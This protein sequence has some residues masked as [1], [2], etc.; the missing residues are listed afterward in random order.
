VTSNPPVPVVIF[1][2][3]G[4]AADLLAFAHRIVNDDGHPSE[5]FHEVQ[6]ELLDMI[7]K[8]FQVDEE[9]AEQLLL[10]ILECVKKKNLITVYRCSDGHHNQPRTNDTS[11][12][13]DD[14][15]CTTELDHTILTALFKAQHLSPAEQL[16]LAL[17][18][19]RADIA[20]SEVFQYGVEWSPGTLEQAMMDALINDRVN[21]V[22][23]LLE[24]GVNIWK[25]LTIPRLE[26]LYNCKQGPANTLRDLNP[27]FKHQ[28][29]ETSSATRLG[30]IS[31]KGAVNVRLKQELKKP[32]TLGYG[33]IFKT[34]GTESSCGLATFF[35][36]GPDP[37]PA[38]C[39][40]YI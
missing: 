37:D 19:N 35:Y 30:N 3:T 6:E 8:T 38:I 17:T 36:A 9:Q 32:C 33:G 18:W 4:R 16:S 26:E 28:K 12:E 1:D 31:S 40:R 14:E 2:G 11:G 7:E 22:Q 39:I 10:E 24:N 15:S 34:G 21:F 13:G 5:L 20:R 27:D 25:F 23:L 29:S